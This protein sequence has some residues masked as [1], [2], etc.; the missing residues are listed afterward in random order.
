[1]RYLDRKISLKIFIFNFFFAEQSWPNQIILFDKKI[2][3]EKNICF[4][5][6]LKFVGGEFWDINS[7]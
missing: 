7:N 1:M 3:G 4:P 5:A 2:L 6:G